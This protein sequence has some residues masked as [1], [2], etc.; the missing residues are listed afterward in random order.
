MIFYRTL[1]TGAVRAFEALLCHLPVMRRHVVV[2]NVPGVVDI[3]KKITHAVCQVNGFS[4]RNSDNK[5]YIL[6]GKYCLRGKLKMIF[7]RQL[8]VGLR[9]CKLYAIG[10]FRSISP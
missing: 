5:F 10:I 1:I 9:K 2:V 6:E 4:L 7:K 8:I 3:E